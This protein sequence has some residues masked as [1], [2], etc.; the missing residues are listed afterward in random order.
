MNLQDCLYI[1]SYLSIK[2][3]KENEVLFNLQNIIQHN[4]TK[5]KSLRHNFGAVPRIIKK[6]NIKHTQD[7]VKKNS[8]VRLSL[9]TSVST[10]YFDVV[11][12]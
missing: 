5:Y 9:T 11:I 2:D 3:D 6:I 8:D 12:A 1:M 4:D 7:T 10:H